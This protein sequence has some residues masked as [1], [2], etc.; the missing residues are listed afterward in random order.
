MR[1]TPRCATAGHVLAAWL[2]TAATA[3]AAVAMKSRRLGRA[4]VTGFVLL[5]G[6]MC[7]SRLCRLAA[8]IVSMAETMLAGKNA[9][10]TGS[11]DEAEI[12]A[13]KSDDPR[14]RENVGGDCVS[15]VVSMRIEDGIAVI[16]VDNP[17]VNALSH[18]VRAASSISSARATTMPASMPS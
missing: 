5:S 7:S 18:E 10:R 16:T 13:S 9:G 6:R 12:T 17:P 14:R 11:G 8:A 1:S 2:A 15:D 4:C 3:D